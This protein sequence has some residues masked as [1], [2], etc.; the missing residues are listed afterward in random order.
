MFFRSGSAGVC[1][2]RARTPKPEAKKKS[3]L[4]PEETCK[5]SVFCD[6]CVDR[7]KFL[8]WLTKQFLSGIM[9]I[10]KGKTSN[11]YAKTLRLF[12]K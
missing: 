10:G 2:Q 9:D 8:K 6:R 5:L 1:A 7:L 3:N 11:G 12:K 4:I